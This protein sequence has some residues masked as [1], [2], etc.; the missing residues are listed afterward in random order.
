VKVITNTHR[1][2]D[3]GEKG[4]EGPWNFLGPDDSRIEGE[5]EYDRI[6]YKGDH[7]EQRHLRDD[8]QNF[9]DNRIYGEKNAG[10]L[11]HNRHLP[12]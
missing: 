11:L 4:D 8:E 10:K 2:G 9:M 5:T 3:E 6:D 12:P 1:A 7:G